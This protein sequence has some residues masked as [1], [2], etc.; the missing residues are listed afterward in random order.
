MN[1]S[2]SRKLLWTL[3][4]L[5]LVA[6]GIYI[7]WPKI[8]AARTPGD[9]KGDRGGKQEPT[10]AIPVVAVRTHRG[11]IGVYYTGLGAVTPVYTVNIQSRVDGQLMDVHYKEGDFVKKGDLLIEID[12]RPYTA[13]LTQ[14][15]G[16][17]IRD[18]ASLANARV[19]LARYQ[20]LVPLR[21][22]PEQTLAT[23]EAQVKQD[24]G[25]V[26]LDR[27]AVDAARTNV[28][29]TKIAAPISG[30]V[31]LRL[32]DPGNIVQTTTTT[33]MLVIT[34]MDPITVIFTI[35]EDQ[36]PA[37]LPKYNAKQALTVEAWDRQMTK[38]IAEGTV[39]S[40]DN[41]IDQTTGTLRIRAN[42]ANPNNALYPNQ[43]VNA[44][45]LVQEKRGVVLV[46]SAVIQRNSSSTFV[47]LV[48]P[49]K[50][51]TIRNVA[52]GTTEGDESEITS[53]LK[54]GDVV[55]MSGADKL[56][57]GSLVN[58]QI[59]GSGGAGK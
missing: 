22:V 9:P 5:V 28:E 14:A 21:A 42:F 11:N 49:N 18:E 12:P 39:G 38:K 48:Q 35:S 26:E 36:L 13:A 7:W 40:L 6:A 27:G 52:V 24:E 55:V 33:P 15:Q 45:L 57:E 2:R 47:F 44:K 37:I 4:L 34:Q 50:T 32:V 8:T 20:T 30:L 54:S 41:Q 56:Q 10:A 58:A 25:T 19:D 16:T 29:Y 23:Q 31:G 43:F 3:A 1:T 46:N 59:Q 51:V 53:G 17:L